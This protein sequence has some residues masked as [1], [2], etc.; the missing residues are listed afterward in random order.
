MA[1]NGL[2][3][4]ALQAIFFFHTILTSGMIERLD[5]LISQYP[6]TG[7]GT[8]EEDDK[9]SLDVCG[10]VQD[11]EERNAAFNHEGVFKDCK[12]FNDRQE[13]QLGI[14]SGQEHG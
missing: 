5:L 13:G 11:L 7:D 1:I 14:V 10:D 6:K 4:P 8:L 9:W 2:R 3:T 12:I